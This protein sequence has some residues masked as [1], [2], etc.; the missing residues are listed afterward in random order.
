MDA[1]AIDAIERVTVW[2]EKKK[3]KKKNQQQNLS[4][5]ICDDE[6]PK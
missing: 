5:G 1:S 3:E 2:T 4:R 6:I